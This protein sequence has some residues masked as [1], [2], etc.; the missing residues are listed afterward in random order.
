MM[1]IC[2]ICGNRGATFLGSTNGQACECPRCG[3]F[4]L[5]GT[6]IDA[7]RRLI[8][9]GKINSTVLS[10]RIR[11]RFDVDSRPV[12][13]FEDDLGLYVDD[14]QVPNPQEQAD[15]LILWIGRS[16]GSQNNWASVKPQRLAALIGAPVA[17]DGSDE[18]S[19]LLV[20]MGERLYSRSTAQN[21]SEITFK[22]NMAGWHA[23]E[24]LRKRITVSRLAFMAMKFNAPNVAQVLNKCFKP[25][26]LRAG[27]ILKPLNEEQPAGLIDNQIRA[28]IR[29]ARFVVADLSDDSNGAYFEA[30][31][32]EGLGIPVIYTCEAKKF[33]A[34]GTH[35]DT[36]HM[37]TIP[38]DLNHLDEAGRLFTA[39][40]RATLPGEAI[41]VD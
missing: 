8:G 7:L 32:A 14:S 2:N 18:N 25:A 24:V 34:N 20:Q 39:T 19:W 12:E 6:A 27:F 26:A 30:G 3:T 21:G 41:L 31:F 36:N 37:H 22:L 4:V 23:Y 11:K 5:I 10:H 16:Q 38:W 13:L 28:A 15:N 9:D 29:T 1:S 33:A 40:I 17:K 35:F